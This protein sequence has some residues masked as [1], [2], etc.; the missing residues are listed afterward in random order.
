MT[1]LRDI[2]MEYKKPYG[3][4][5]FHKWIYRFFI[6]KFPDIELNKYFRKAEHSRKGSGQIATEYCIS[7]KNEMLVRRYL[8]KSKYGNRV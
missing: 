6:P 1:S 2:W 4:G 5:N 3:E 7:K 8:D